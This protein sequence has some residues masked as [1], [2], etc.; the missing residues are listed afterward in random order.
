[1]GAR[2]TVT[3]REVCVS[4]ARMAAV[5]VPDI[6]VRVVALVIGLED[7]GAADARVSGSL[8]W[9]LRHFDFCGCSWVDGWQIMVCLL[10]VEIV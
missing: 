9:S 6:L 8:A 5:S 1:V 3:L 10:L 2:R 7:T 4:G